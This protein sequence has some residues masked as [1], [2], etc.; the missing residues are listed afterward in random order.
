MGEH[1]A[2]SHS[3]ASKFFFVDYICQVMFNCDWSDKVEKG[4]ETENS[5]M[6][7]TLFPHAFFSYYGQAIRGGL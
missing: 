7:G 2:A 4:V 5:T 6:L 1:M 3:R